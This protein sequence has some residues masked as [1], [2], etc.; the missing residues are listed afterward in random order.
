VRHE[1]TSSQSIAEIFIVD[2]ARLSES[3]IHHCLSS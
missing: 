1:H 3:S 2:D